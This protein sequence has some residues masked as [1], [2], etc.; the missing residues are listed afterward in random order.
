MLVV[1]NK[2]VF[3]LDMRGCEKCEGEKSGNFNHLITQII[4]LVIL[5]KSL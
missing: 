2:L 1:H 5:L 3:A 4:I